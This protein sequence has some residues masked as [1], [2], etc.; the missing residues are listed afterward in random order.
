MQ[1]T[2]LRICLSNKAKNEGEENIIPILF[3][4]IFNHVTH[5]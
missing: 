4:N 2:T 1:W 5:K 3:I